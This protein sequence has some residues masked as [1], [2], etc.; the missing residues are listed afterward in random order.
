MYRTLYQGSSSGWDCVKSQ[1]TSHLFPS[2]WRDLEEEALA[3][4]KIL[5]QSLWLLCWGCTEKEQ[6]QKQGE[7]LRGQLKG[8][9]LSYQ[10]TFHKSEFV[11]PSLQKKKKKAN[12]DAAE[13]T[14]TEVG[15]S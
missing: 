8:I 5:R 15:K 4:S 12:S 6:G 3:Q 14:R 9:L 1:K 10:V 7:Q 13:W 2:H 11:E